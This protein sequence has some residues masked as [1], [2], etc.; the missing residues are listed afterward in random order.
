LYFS[1]TE[2]DPSNHPRT[3]TLFLVLALSEIQKSKFLQMLGGTVYTDQKKISG[4]LKIK[5][6]YFIFFKWK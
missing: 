1:D 4:G 5:K 6:N 3:G 2:G